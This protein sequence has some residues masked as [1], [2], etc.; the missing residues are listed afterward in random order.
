MAKKE[1]T[2]GKSQIRNTKSETRGKKSQISNPKS[3]TRIKKGSSKSTPKSKAE[4]VASSKNAVLDI[5]DH[6]VVKKVSETITHNIKQSEHWHAALFVIVVIL[7]AYFSFQASNG[8]Y[9]APTKTPVANNQQPATN[10]PTTNTPVETPVEAV[11]PTD[12]AWL[13]QVVGEDVSVAP[14]GTGEFILRLKNTGKATWYRDTAQA[15]RLGTVDPADAP[16][17]FMAASVIEESGK[18]RPAVGRNRV[19]ML[20]KQV[21][22]GEMA[23]FRL[24]VQAADWNGTALKPGSYKFTVGLLVEGKGSLSKKPLV[25]RLNVK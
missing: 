9:N 6:A 16:F 14:G 25:W 19:E 5:A 15:F 4:S 13:T 8:S 18:T 22:P 21:A 23:T 3:Q 11:F 7:A 1:P 10:T 24:Q 12:Y 2:R 17:P 20:Q